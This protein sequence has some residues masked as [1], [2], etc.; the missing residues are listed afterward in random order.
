MPPAN[1]VPC[2]GDHAV[3]SC[4]LRCSSEPGA[5]VRGCEEVRHRTGLG[6]WSG[7]RFGGPT[8][9]KVC[10]RTEKKEE[11]KGGAV[12]EGRARDREIVGE[13]GGVG[14]EGDDAETEEFRGVA[15]S[16]AAFGGSAGAGGE[17]G[18][19]AA[20][21]AAGGGKGSVAAQLGRLQGVHCWEKQQHQWQ[22][23]GIGRSNADSCT[24]GGTSGSRS[25]WER[26]DVGGAG[27]SGGPVA[28]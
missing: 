18:A 12:G 28:A 23:Q 17:V 13:I 11:G 22:G 2:C 3:P 21:G 8:R 5:A 19:D 14:A 4:Q 16:R 24:S 20:A 7:W 10:G 27:S 15:G 25:S 9:R 1:W 26:G 6:V